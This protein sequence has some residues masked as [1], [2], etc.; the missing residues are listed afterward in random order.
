M[1]QIFGV[2]RFDPTGDGRRQDQAVIESVL[3]LFMEHEG[4]QMHRPAWKDTTRGPEQSLLEVFQICRRHGLRE[5]MQRRRGELLHDLPT[6]RPIPITLT[7][8]DLQR[9]LLLGG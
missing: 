1:L 4:V 3:C 2:E 7:S 6:D 9:A 5:P 8:D